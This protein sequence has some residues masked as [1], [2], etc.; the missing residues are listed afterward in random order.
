M[1]LSPTTPGERKVKTWYW[2]WQSGGYNSCRAETR[3][4]ALRQAVEMG[5]PKAAM[6]VTLVPDERT[7]R[8]VDA[9]EMERLD[10]WWGAM[11]N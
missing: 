8:A 6:T 3:E 5:K 11:L 7:L 10:R 4:D 9:R 1:G 2:E